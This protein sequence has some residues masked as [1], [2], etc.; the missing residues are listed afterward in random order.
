MQVAS[1]KK[2]TPPQLAAEYGIDVKKVLAWIKTGELPAI[3]VATD[4][5]GRPRYAIDVADIAIF[6]ASRSA[7]P[8]PKITRRRRR[9]TS[10]R[11]YF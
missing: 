9:D 3:N 6:E 7:T 11:E 1:R 10:I 4:R 8:Q 5:N 2:R